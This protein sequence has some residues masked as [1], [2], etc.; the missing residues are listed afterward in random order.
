MVQPPLSRALCEIV[1]RIIAIAYP[2]PDI[3]AQKAVGVAIAVLKWWTAL[4]I[5]KKWRIK[6][7]C[8]LPG[9]HKLTYNEFHR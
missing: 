8:V 4:I 6:P 1:L 2:D 3:L 7:L 9:T 5:R